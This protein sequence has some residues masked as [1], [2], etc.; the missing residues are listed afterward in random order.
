MR[1]TRKGL[2]A[3]AVGALA[4]AVLAGGGA[5]SASWTAGALGSGQVTTPAV[6]VAQASFP[7]LGA[8]FTNTHTSLTTTGSFTITNPG[9]VAGVASSTITSAD[10]RA[11][12]LA[13]RIWPVASTAACTPA[14]AVPTTAATG[15]WAATTVAGTA[16]AAG[17][18]QVL[19]VRTT[20]P[21]AQ[22]NALASTTGAISVP[23][24]LSV[25]L[26]GTGTGWTA[27]AA[28]VTATHRTQAIYPLDAG[29]A[30]T[31]G[32]RWH[33][34]RSA[35][36]TGVCLDVSGGG[37]AGSLAIGWTCTQ[38]NG[39][40]QGN[41]LWQV[42]PVSEADRTLV[43]LRPRHQT[44][45]RLAV[46]G[47]GRQSIAAAAA[48]AAQ[49]WHVQRVSAST[50]QLVSAVDGRCLS[51]PT[52]SSGTARTTVDCTDAAAAVLSPQLQP[53]GFTWNPGLIGI[54]SN[55]ALT[56]G[57]NRADLI[58]ERES[59]PGTWQ[60]VAFAQPAAYPTMI[61]IAPAN[62]PTGTSS[63][64][65]RYADGT[66]AYA[67]VLNRSSSNVVSAVSGTG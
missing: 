22:R 56:V 58:L 21:L 34:I 7:S 33:T 9:T 41:Q 50:V 13:L 61:T 31:V 62:L 1:R 30:P 36:S 18:S 14:T 5:A 40:P 55:A 12:Q 45:T 11:P 28:G 20:L 16:L 24:I 38:A 29:L 39:A 10:A 52:T 60:G 59:A 3:F 54:G 27:A 57:A 2:T 15:T 37:G 43:T 26:V 48:G 44:G 66:V 6:R 23:A 65:L 46:D 32:S 35:A 63:L 8:T 4:F 64:R 51:L 53:L 17:A 67:F 42:I 19:C 49:Q 25:S 47:T